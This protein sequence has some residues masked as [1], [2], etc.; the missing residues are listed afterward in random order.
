MDASAL[1]LRTKAIGYRLFSDVEEKA[2]SIFQS[3][4]WE[5][6]LLEWAMKNSAMKT[7][8]LRFVDIFPALHTPRQIVS[9]LRQYFPSSNREFPAFL[10]I[11]LEAASPTAVSRSLLARETAAMMTRMARKFIAGA[12]IEEALGV[13]RNIRAEG[14]TY[15]LDLLGEAVVSE[16][17][18]DRYMDDYIRVLGILGAHADLATH[19]ISIKLS[20]LYSQFDPLNES[21]SKRIVK[22]RLRQIFRAARQIGAF[23]NIDMEQYAF[24]GLTLRI[25]KEFLEEEEFRDFPDA[26]VVIQAYL[27]ESEAMLEDVIRWV[28]RRGTPIT[29]RLVKGAYWDFELIHARLMDWPAPVFKKKNETDANFERLTGILLRNY[30]AIKTAIGSH[31]IRSIAHAM[32]CA[33]S[34]GI[35]PSGLEFQMLFGM[36]DSIKRAILKSA[37]PLRV[38]T[39]IGEL[40][41]GMAYLVRRL[42][43]NT[44]NESFLRQDYFMG[45]PPEELLKNPQ[46]SEPA[47]VLSRTPPKRSVDEFENEP[48]TDFSR[49]ESVDK[50]RKALDAVA[51]ELGRTYPMVIGKEKLEGKEIA[52]SINPSRTDQ[53]VGRIAQASIADADHALQTAQIAFEAWQAVSP[54]NRAKYLFRAAEIMAARRVELA[55]LKVYEVGK[56][57]READADVAEAIDYL[58]YYGRQM[59][60]L[61]AQTLTARLPGETNEYIYRGRGVGLIIAPWNFPLAILTGMSSAAVVAGNAVILKPAEQSPIIAAHLMQIYE[62][63]GIPAGVV[64]LLPGPGQPLGEY[65]VKSPD[66]SFIAFTGSQEVGLRIDRLAA[67]HPARNAVKRVIAEMGGKNAVIID[68]SADLDDAVLGVTASAFSYQGQKCSAASRVIV[69]D[70]V[71]DTFLPRLIEAARSLKVGPAEDPGAQVGPVIDNDA[72]QKILGYIKLGKEQAR[73]VLET[74]VSHLR[75]GFYVGPTIFADVAPESPLAQEEIFG[76]VLAVI[77]ARDFEDALH[78]ANATRFGLTGGLYSRT[79]KHVELARR[80]FLVGNL[81]INRKITGAIVR[82]QPFGGFKMS[83]VGSKAGGPDY[84]IQFMLPQTISENVMRRGFAPLEEYDV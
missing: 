35:E 24:G 79:P 4:W 3:Q 47:A 22:Q 5:N 71:Y 75:D 70:S 65:L 2:P 36:G 25:A 56:G 45:V 61:N 13:L 12:D 43:E 39:P 57:W 41:P 63:A 37:Y 28:R 67:E 81:Y 50:M 11:G 82:R 26:G 60:R 7:Q 30:P 27:R 76:P 29:V 77:R 40:L 73:L 54:E 38:Y 18:A 6:Q 59:I 31:N 34:L 52:V 53:V 80:R 83:G 72:L 55:A 68:E 48:L 58:R 78:I 19:N 1:E 17:E 20:S 33:E 84:L 14:M 16:V 62:E 44:S 64:N 15:T 74:D 69:L 42:L 10:R 32:A 8:M 46:D 23:V 49:V 66:V 21:G 9:H 51:A